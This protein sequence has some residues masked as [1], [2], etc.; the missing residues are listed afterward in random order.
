MVR[1]LVLTGFLALFATT[2]YAADIYA[3]VNVVAHIPRPEGGVFEILTHGSALPNGGRTFDSFDFSH[4]G[5]L[6]TPFT[7]QANYLCASASASVEIDRRLVQ[8]STYIGMST[9]VRLKAKARMDYR[10]VGAFS[11]IQ[12]WGRATIQIPIACNG[13]VAPPLGGLAVRYRLDGEHDISSSDSAVTVDAPRPFEACTGGHCVLT[14][15]SFD[16]P[17]EGS[18]FNVYIDLFPRIRID[19]LQGHSGWTVYAVSDY[20]HTM[21]LEGMDVLDV[22]GDP[23]PNVRVVVPGANGA[24]NDTFLTA[25]EY[26]EDAANSPTT[27]TTAG[28]T[29]STTNLVTTT[30]QS[31]TSTTGVFTTTT[32]GGASTTTLVGASTTTTL[33][34]P[35]AGI[36][37]LQAADCRCDLLP[38][39]DG[40]KRPIAKGLAKTCKTVD[41][42]VAATGKAQQR[43]GQRA[44]AA[45]RRTLAT[46]NGRKGNAIPDGCREGLRTFLGA[47][48]ADLT[49][50]R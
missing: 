5:A 39:C 33:P 13:S 43:L 6:C 15:P 41:K 9:A 10:N 4:G 36:L 21:T 38:G 11:A 40:L 8:T 19:N 50:A 28:P 32:I 7:G 34:P 27:T 42:A 46:V 2:T 49:P 3:D 18:T 16:C 14:Y 24:V 22:N 17:P 31:T 35:C 45:A 37:G 12:L 23:L 47:L 26:E 44:A 25:A 29:T 30:T 20:S 1:V 48:Q